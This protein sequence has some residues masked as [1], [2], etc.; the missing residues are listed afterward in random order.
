MIVDANLANLL[1]TRFWRVAAILKLT[2]AFSRSAGALGKNPCA[3]NRRGRRTVP[4]I[5]IHIMTHYGTPTPAKGGISAVTESCECRR[6]RAAGHR[7]SKAKTDRVMI[8]GAVCGLQKN[9]SVG[10]GLDD[11]IDC[12]RRIAA[13]RP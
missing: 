2:V 11:P 13:I 10:A 12:A 5:R 6:E 3:S 9:A 7:R 8:E 1:K 4:A